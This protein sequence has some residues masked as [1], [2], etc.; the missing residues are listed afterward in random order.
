MA[1]STRSNTKKALR[2]V[3]RSK[4]TDS[5]KWLQ[6]A[7][8]KRLEALAKCIAAE[9]V[10]VPTATAGMETGA[11]SRGRSGDDAMEVC[12]PA[13]KLNKS[14]KKIVKRKGKKVSVLAGKNQFHKKGKK[15][16]R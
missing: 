5:T 15:G 7:E 10:K 16:R 2:T 3:R 13:A 11:E 4:V 6:E 12:K 1:K 9:P 8:Q 14:S